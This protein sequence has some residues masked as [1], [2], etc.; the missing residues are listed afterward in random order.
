MKKLLYT[1]L[2]VSII[3]SA[4]EEEDVT[5]INNNNNSSNNTYVP[6]DNFEQQLINFGLD[7]VLDDYVLTSSIDTVLSLDVDD[8]NISSLVGIEDFISL[9]D[10]HCRDNNLTSLDVS[11]N[12]NLISL[13]CQVNNINN[14]NTGS[15]DIEDIWCHINNLIN[16][17]LSNNHNL[18]QIYVDENNLES[19]NLK[20]GNS[21][22]ICCIATYDNPNLSCILVDDPNTMS[23]FVFMSQDPQHYLS[24]SCP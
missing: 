6:D 14:L 18:K 16:L 5:P 23:P 3:F 9:E 4:C 10:L 8:K 21:A 7:N 24:N 22:N 15:I 11:N 17:D 20:N 19:L 12:T 13:F 1:L 2:A